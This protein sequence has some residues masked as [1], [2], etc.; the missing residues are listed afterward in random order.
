MPDFCNSAAKSIRPVLSE[1]EINARL[2]RT[3]SGTGM[4][5]D[6]TAIIFFQCVSA[7]FRAD[8]THFGN[9]ILAD[10]RDVAMPVEFGNQI[11]R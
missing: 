4:C 2:T 11:G 10:R 3:M 5:L 8:S 6:C 1:T 7:I 9:M